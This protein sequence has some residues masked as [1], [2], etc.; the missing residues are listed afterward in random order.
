MNSECI[1]YTVRRRDGANEHFN[2]RK[3]AEEYRA[4]WN[5]KNAV[6]M[7]RYIVNDTDLTIEKV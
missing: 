6:H 3:E 2:T 7:T 4:Y 5:L 1:K